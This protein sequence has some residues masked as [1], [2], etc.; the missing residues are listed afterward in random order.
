[1]D[2]DVGLAWY[3]PPD[4]QPV[5]LVV[6]GGRVVDSTP[7]ARPWALGRTARQIL[8][9]AEREG[10]TVVWTP[11]SAPPRTFQ[12]HLEATEPIRRWAW[13]GG[14]HG[15]HLT[16]GRTGDGWYVNDTNEPWAWRYNLAG[17]AWAECARR[18]GDGRWTRVNASYGQGGEPADD[19][20]L[21]DGLAALE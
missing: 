8:D 11:L 18:M 7:H 16:F 4:G 6:D 5:Y 13:S 21:P 9:R 2:S 1:V 10:A 3:E 19:P 15:G 12:P 14:H 20:P 17:E